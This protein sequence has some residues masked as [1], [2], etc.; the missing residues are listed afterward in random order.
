MF[1]ISADGTYRVEADGYSTPTLTE[2][3]VVGVKPLTEAD[4]LPEGTLFGRW[5]D[6]DGTVYWDE[7][8]VYDMFST[9]LGTAYIRNEIAIWD[10]AEKH[11]VRVADYFPID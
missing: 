8:E 11:E 2:G 3:Y 1:G 7:V 5:T 6:E 4:T 10:I 9:A